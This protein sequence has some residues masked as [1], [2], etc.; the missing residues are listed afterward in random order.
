[1]PWG[2]PSS[3]SGG[4]TSPGSWTGLGLLVTAWHWSRRAAH[5]YYAQLQAEACWV[6]RELR[7][8]WNATFPFSRR[9]SAARFPT[10]SDR[11]DQRD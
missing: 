7:V 8:G 10:S 1:M 2:S 4:Y 6:L 9:S 5:R 11:P 3:S